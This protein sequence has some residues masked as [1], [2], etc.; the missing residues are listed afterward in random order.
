MFGTYLR[1]ELLN[2]RKQTIIIAIGMALAIALV[3]IVNAVS[4]GVKDAQASVLQSVYGV[5][6]DITVS[7]PATAPTATGQAGGG[8]RFDFGANSGTDAG[9]SRSVNTSRLEP[10]RGAT[11]M[12][13]S[14]LATVQ[15]VQNVSAAAAVLS[16]TNTSFSGTLPDFQQLRQERQAGG[17]GAAGG[18]AAAPS[19]APTGGAD[20]A[21]G[22]SFNV[23]SFSV[24]GLDPAGKS[25]GPLASV[26]LT[27]GR[28]FTKADAGKDVVVLDSAYAKTAS[29]AVGDTVT[30]GGTDFSVIGVVAATG[31]D[32]STA[33]NAYIPLDVAQTLS[34]QTAKI[35]S[36]YVT[37]ASSSDISQIKT[38]LTKALPTATVS[39][40]ADLASD[41]SGSLGS[42]GDLI[43]NLGTWLSLI[44]LAAAFLIAIL[45]TIS[46]VTRRTREF[47]TLKAIGWSNGRIV[48]QVAGES[49]VQGVIGGI[50]GV[51][52][53]LLGVLIVNLV[54]PTLTGSV[55]TRSGFADAA[56]RG[57]GAVGT[58][59]TNAPG[60]GFGGAGG[61]FGGAGGGFAGARQAAASTSEIALHAP[62][63]LW[64]ILG[65]VGLAVLGGLIAGA[66]G[67]WR[68]SRLRPAA[69]L[70]SVA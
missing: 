53:G 60:G 17:T 6:T 16:L 62:I 2:R 64:I 36:V 27:S 44:V 56:G 35:S 65:A 7:E 11:V 70:R 33:S 20:G 49:V 58:A 66:I 61:G 47:G 69:A 5:G 45:F 37:A 41:V 24:L 34:G 59:A 55:N 39:T 18:D 30:I 32:S 31:S 50:I 1:R 54:S 15:K 67:G 13:D 21:G 26:T 51:A 40:E 43:A 8:G 38:D 57:A 68:A 42:A 19:P 29:K 4:A 3:I 9:G 22:S 63:T 23:D 48:G 28:T 10:T 46:G 12:A 14:T 52:V 25:V